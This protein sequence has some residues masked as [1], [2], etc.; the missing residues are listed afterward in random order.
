MS[1]QAYL[2]SNSKK[3]N[4]ARNVSQMKNAD[5]CHADLH[6]SDFNYVDEKQEDWLSIKAEIDNLIQ[7][8]K[9]GYELL[10]KSKEVSDYWNRVRDE[11]RK[12]R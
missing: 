12:T 8:S 3:I 4:D 2:T 1:D 10:Q 6:D 9:S 5:N 7:T 11:R